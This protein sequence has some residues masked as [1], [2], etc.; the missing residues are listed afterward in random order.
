MKLLR[1]LR[2]WILLEGFPDLLQLRVLIIDCIDFH[3]CRLWIHVHMW[4]G[5][6]VCLRVCMCRCAQPELTVKW[7][8]GNIKWSWCTSSLLLHQNTFSVTYH[9]HIETDFLFGMTNLIQSQVGGFDCIF[10][11]GSSCRDLFSL[12]VTLWIGNNFCSTHNNYVIW[13]KLPYLNLFHLTH[14]HICGWKRSRRAIIKM[15]YTHKVY[16]IGNDLRKTK[17]FDQQISAYS[18]LQY[19]L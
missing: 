12:Q 15:N 9:C 17:Y 13:I 5:E 3:H 18:Q 19:V 7:R 11:R 8:T 4:A 2:K 10:C 1:C 16:L 6:H 14:T